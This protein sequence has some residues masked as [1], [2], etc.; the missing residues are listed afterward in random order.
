M[1]PNQD[2]YLMLVRAIMLIIGPLLAAHGVSASDQT[3]LSTGVQALVGA[4]LT[5]GP[6]IW[7]MFAHTQAATVAK[8]A[9]MDKTQVSDNG[10]T[11]TILDPAL[12]KS[13]ADN[14][15]PPVH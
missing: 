1:T 9:A 6:I 14:A 13:A 4:A 10:K 15:T 7:G 8:V 3:A 11:I 2:Q 12:A 5:I